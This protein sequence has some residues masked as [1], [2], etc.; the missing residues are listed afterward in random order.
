MTYNNRAMLAMIAS[1]LNPAS[2]HTHGDH[3][4]CHND[5][6]EIEATP[7]RNALIFMMADGTQFMITS[8]E[9]I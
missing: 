1:A 2:P 5:L 3:I 8:E 6:A 4:L 9:V 7:D